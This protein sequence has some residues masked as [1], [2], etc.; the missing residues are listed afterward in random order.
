MRALIVANGALPRPHLVRRAIESADLVVAADGGA[1]ALWAG[2]MRCDLILGDFDSIAA[3]VFPD[4]PRV[5]AS[6][7]NYTDL[8]KALAY[9]VNRKATSIE[10]MG[11]TGDRLDHTFGALS[12]LVKYG[13]K[14][15]V[16]LVDD[17]GAARLV[18][19][20]LQWAGVLDRVVSL[21][22]VTPAGGVTTTGLRWELTDASLAAGVRDG[23]SNVAIDDRI[24]VRADSGDLVVYVHHG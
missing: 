14:A 21:L 6:D 9:L 18:D 2:K 16:T 11:V 15:L 22:P 12:A 19:G 17:V 24:R 7:Q 10:L 23:I 4:V 8:D 1:N 3:S 5:D 13:R 20:E